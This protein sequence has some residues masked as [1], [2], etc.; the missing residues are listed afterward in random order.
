MSNPPL[1]LTV[2]GERHSLDVPG[3]APLLMVLRNDLQL[4]GPKYGCGLGQCGACSVLVDG[5]CA[6]ACVI[7]V[8]GVAGR[9][10]TTLEGLG[11]VQSPHIVQQAFIEEQA[12]QCGYCLNGMIMAT[13]ALLKA[14]PRPT[15]TEIRDALAHNLCRCGT[16]IEILQAVHRAA[17]RLAESK[18]A[19]R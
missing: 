18:E 8:R 4:N 2:N 11:N 5:K 6:R 16:H 7:P 14:N 3:D 9:H 1:S 15:D 17:R 19:Q 13:V 10:V 12:A